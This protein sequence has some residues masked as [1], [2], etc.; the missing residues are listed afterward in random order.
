MSTFHFKQFDIVSGGDS[1]SVGTDGVLLGAWAHVPDGAQRILD[2]GTGSGVIA[3][4]LAQ[5]TRL[6]LITGIDIN[7]EAVKTAC[8]NAAASPFSSR[9]DMVC[10]DI[11]SYAPDLCF[12]M[13]VSNP[14]YFPAGCI[15]KGSAR[16]K[17]RSFETLTPQQLIEAAARLLSDKGVFAVILPENIA[18]DFAFCAWENDLRLSARTDVITVSGK[19][20]KRAL[21][22]F[23]RD[24]DPIKDYT[25]STIVLC[26]PSGNRT[27]E[28]KR[29]T[30]DF[31]L[32]K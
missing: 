15:K 21:M 16:A 31:Y 7:A 17:A 13:I 22:Q 8:N 4:M 29:L 20:P 18:E 23:V 30:N 6:S 14:P 2:V 24:E 28:M 27:Q 9:I 32:E 26:D 3:I 1:M 12:D 25:R 19:P 5:R 10:A 11:R